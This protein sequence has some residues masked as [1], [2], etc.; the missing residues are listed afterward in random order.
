MKSLVFI[1]DYGSDALAT[2]EVLEAIRRFAGAP[3]FVHVVASRPFNT[4]NTA[5]LLEQLHRGMDENQVKQTVF[6]LNTDPRTHTK[7]VVHAAGGSIFV[8]AYLR[9][10][11]V[12]MTPNA[13]YCLS[14]VKQNIE[15]LVEVRVAA[16]GTQFRSRDIFSPVVA[17]ALTGDIAPFLG[18]E[19]SAEERVPDI[20]SGIFLLHNDNYGNMKLFLQKKAL[21]LQKI[22]E[23]DEI[24]IQIG[25]QRKEGV[26][27]ASTIFTVLPGTMALAPGSSGP[28]DNPYYEL[29]VR[30]DGDVK[31][32][33]ADAFGWPEPGEQIFLFRK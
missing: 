10:G 30:F 8:V 5:F 12:V 26:R 1:A 23:G 7:E 19:L 17:R 13:G 15:K 9:G 31:Q 25:Q 22:Y 14:L 4:I 11:A 33:A 18:S 16:D 29:S 6:F 21:E 2:S 24:T 27:V 3:F 28:K 32:S 20:P